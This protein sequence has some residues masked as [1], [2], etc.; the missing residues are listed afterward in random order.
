MWTN[1]TATYPIVVE[2]GGLS[3]LGE[4][5]P[6]GVGKL[7]FLSTEDV[8]Q[9]HGDVLQAW[10]SVTESVGPAYNRCNMG[11]VNALL[12]LEHLAERSPYTC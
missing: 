7:F 9:F 2:C 1:P 3:K 12:T 10:N 11:V 8:W 4:H 5:I 6:A